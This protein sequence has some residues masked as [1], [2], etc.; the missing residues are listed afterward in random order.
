MD[1]VSA[2]ASFASDLSEEFTAI[3]WELETLTMSVSPD[4]I[5]NDKY[6]KEDGER[7]GKLVSSHGAAS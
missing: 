7:M 3:N 1:L 2:S 6:G 4:T 5:K